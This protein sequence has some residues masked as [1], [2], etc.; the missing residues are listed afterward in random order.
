VTDSDLVQALEQLRSTLIAVATGGPRIGDVNGE[1]QQAYRDVS[2]ALTRRRLENPIPYA[3]P[4]V[5]DDTS[6]LAH[7]CPCRMG[8]S[9]PLLTLN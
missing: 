4:W 6:N 3:D 9:I 2:L 5:V 8:A 7:R 1:Y